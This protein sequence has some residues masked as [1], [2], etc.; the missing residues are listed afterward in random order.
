MLKEQLQKDLIAAMKAKDDA[1]VRTLRMVK[2]AI[3]R[4][5]TSGADMVADDE[6][7]ISIFKKERAQ[8]QDSIEQF[9]KGNREDLA[10]AEKEEIEVIDRKLP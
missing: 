5:E 7:I 6:R 8:R 9:E 10:S 1:T 4:Y 2:T 3:M